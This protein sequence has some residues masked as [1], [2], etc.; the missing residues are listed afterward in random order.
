M[1][2]GTKVVAIDNDKEE[3]EV[4]VSTL[5]SLGLACIS[6]NYPEEMP[7]Q[8]SL[9]TGLRILFLDIHLVGGTSPGGGGNVFNAPVSMI[10]RLITERNGPYALITWS[11]TDLHDGLMNR[12]SQSATLADR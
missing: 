10:E 3:L 4:I 9:V 7:P 1:F 12:I 5:R 8:P 6:Y 11:S 2:P